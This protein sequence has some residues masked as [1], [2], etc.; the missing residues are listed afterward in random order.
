MFLTGFGYVYV[1]IAHQCGTIVITL[2]PEGRAGAVEINLNR[3]IKH[4]KG[5]EKALP[6]VLT[7]QSAF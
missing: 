1:D 7:G 4:I 6:K 3:Y 5:D 2:A